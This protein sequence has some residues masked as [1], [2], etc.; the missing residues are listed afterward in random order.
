MQ[1]V[2]IKGTFKNKQLQKITLLILEN[3]KTI[4]LTR[5]S[6]PKTI[7]KVEEIAKR[8]KPK[9]DIVIS[10][11]DK[12]EVNLVQSEEIKKIKENFLKPKQ[13]NKAGFIETKHV[14]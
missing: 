1:A 14:V 13:Y 5:E 11:T 8:K 9:E 2:V 12:I 6:H 3:L 10:K 7:A 4:E